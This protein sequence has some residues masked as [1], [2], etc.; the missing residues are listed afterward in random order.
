MEIAYR[1]EQGMEDFVPSS[2]AKIEPGATQVADPSNA[3]AQAAAAAAVAV[4]TT[5]ESRATLVAQLE[6]LPL[7]SKSVIETME[8]LKAE[9]LAPRCAMNEYSVC[10]Y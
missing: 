10:T 4:K 8:S 3:A 6:D 2:A 1:K 7:D 5:P 9:G